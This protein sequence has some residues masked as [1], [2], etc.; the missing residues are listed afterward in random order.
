MDAFQL[1]AGEA[2]DVRSDD[3]RP[4]VTKG[5]HLGGALSTRGPGDHDDT[6]LNAAAHR[7]TMGSG[8]VDSGMRAR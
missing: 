7:E 2:L 4:L 6:V 5:G 3:D 1:L 8:D